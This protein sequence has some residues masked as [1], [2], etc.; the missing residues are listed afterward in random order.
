MTSSAAQEHHPP[1]VTGRRGGKVLVGILLTWMVPGAG[2]L[3]LGR[4]GKFVLYFTLITFAYVFGMWLADFRNV[5]LEKHPL[6]FLAQI[7][8]GGATIP[9]ML[10]TKH[11]ALESVNPGLD[12]GV[13]YTSVAGLLNLCVMVDVYETAF[14]QQAAERAP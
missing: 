3:Y 14:P 1:P 13:L 11:L 12:A 9:A 7:F 10:L 2:H 8:Y 4:R 5:S 6:H